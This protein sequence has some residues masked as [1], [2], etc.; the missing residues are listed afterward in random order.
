MGGAESP[1]SQVWPQVLA[2]LGGV[3]FTKSTGVQT[4]GKNLPH[5]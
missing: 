2:V 1:G 3:Q 4:L 5:L